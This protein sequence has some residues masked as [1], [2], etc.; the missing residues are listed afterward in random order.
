V[1]RVRCALK[2]SL[3]ARAAFVGGVA[4]TATGVVL[5]QPAVA[6]AGGSGAL[7]TAGVFLREARG[8]GRTL[9]G[10]LQMVARRA[11]LRYAP[12]VHHQERVAR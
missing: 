10:T 4:L 6:L 5:D 2:A 8:L 9:Y 1:L 11:G 12:P 3:L 7:L